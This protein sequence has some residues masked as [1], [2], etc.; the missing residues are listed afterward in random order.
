MPAAGMHTGDHPSLTTI[1]P[2]SS[3][4]LSVP[5]V[6]ILFSPCSQLF[7]ALRNTGA[8]VFGFVV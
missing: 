7:I 2:Y 6:F 4:S 1:P 3:L 5:S 8:F